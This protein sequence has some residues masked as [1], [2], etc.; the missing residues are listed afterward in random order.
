LEFG[1][2]L[3]TASKAPTA[4]SHLSIYNTTYQWCCEG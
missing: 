3:A 2:G 1:Q 4:I